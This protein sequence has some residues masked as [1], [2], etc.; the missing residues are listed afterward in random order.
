MATLGAIAGTL[1]CAPLAA[2]A[3]P[4]I[5]GADGD[6]WNTAPTYVVKGGAFGQA[7]F[8]QVGQQSAI[9]QVSP[10]QVTLKGLKDGAHTLTVIQVNNRNGGGDDDDDDDERPV[11]R[12]PYEQA[13]R[14]FV[15]DTKKP[16]AVVIAGPATITAP[17]PLDVTWTGGEKG[18]TFTWSVVVPN[19]PGAKD[20]T[21]VQGPVD[22][23]A[24][25]ASVPGLAA[26]SYE[27]TITQRDLAG[28]VSAVAKLPVTVAPAPAPQAPLAVPAAAAPPAAA[29][30]TALPP[31]VVRLP[32]ANTRKL[33][34]KRAATLRVRR[35]V[36]RWSRGP[37]G[38]SLY[39]LQL[40]RVRTVKSTTAAT[41]VSL[42]KVNSVFPR[43]TRFRTP[44]LTRGACYVWRV[45]PYRAG[46][47]TRKPLGVSH[48]CISRLAPGQRSRS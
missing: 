6:Q 40:F 44:T 16:K 7:W 33:R 30:P 24:A 48:F 29:P 42:R 11:N 10:F 2:A 31:T 47:F 34:P 22:T 19:G 9:S 17:A 39:N 13:V 3:P 38:T 8:W 32:A 41:A 27:L 35:P 23:T 46:S 20:D 18:A 15:L 5:S 36:L 45:W 21:L 12:P 14:T 25:A 28:N 1:T 26:G 43:T 4:V 37:R